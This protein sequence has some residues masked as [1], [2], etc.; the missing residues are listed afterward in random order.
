MVLA[1]TFALIAAVV[2]G[3][4]VARA[5][6]GAA[7]VPPPAPAPAPAPGQ[8]APAP[9][10]GT[11]PAGPVVVQPPAD[12]DSDPAWA[13]YDGAFRDA[14]AGE[15]KLSR[16]RLA[17][18][19]SRWPGHPAHVRA[20]VL[21]GEREPRRDDPNAPSN[22]A[23]GEFVFW[24]TLGG[25]LLSGNLCVMI[26]CSTDREYAGVYT[27]T[28][29]GSLAA[30]LLATRRGLRQGEAQLYN[31]VQT[32]GAWNSLLINDGF[33]EDA[34]EAGVSIALQFGGLAA[35]VG[36]WQ[37]WKPTRGD[38]ALANTFLFW[39]A[40]LTVWGHLMADEEPTIR[41]VVAVSDL[42]LL[43]GAVISSRVEVSR[44]RTL[45]IDV[46]G[47]LGI[48]TGGLVAV[49]TDSDTG[50]GTALMLGTLAGLGIGIA[51]TSEWDKAPPVKVAPAVVTG[52]NRSTGYGVSAGFSF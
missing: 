37:A 38:V 52:P 42:A 27:L 36:L 44:G 9:D 7:P 26:D 32:W 12:F 19:A 28:I 20:S 11:A 21:L 17:E 35:G 14:A 30:S 34:Q 15:L 4:G 16:S 2:L 22:V 50:A 46:G 1:R 51:A 31:S 23:R 18:I 5:Q 10:P 3:G 13:A 8:P 41:A 6:P 33:A 45:L 29:G 48:M 25:V 24:T 40:M 47:V 39:G 49:A 43:A